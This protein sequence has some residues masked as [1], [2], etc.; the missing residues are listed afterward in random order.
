M[1]I[2][3]GTSITEQDAFCAGINEHGLPLKQFEEARKL[4]LELSPEDARIVLARL[5]EEFPEDNINNFVLP[6]LIKSLLIVLGIHVV[7]Y[8]IY[9]Y[10]AGN[11][12]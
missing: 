5:Q 7:G 9:R 10:V 3:L 6:Q 12:P 4:A 2:L 11:A 8:I 1:L